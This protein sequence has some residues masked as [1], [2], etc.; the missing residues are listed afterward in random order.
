MRESYE[1]IPIELRKK[2]EQ[3]FIEQQTPEQIQI[4]SS[5]ALPPIEHFVENWMDALPEQEPEIISGLL[6][7]GEKMILQAPSK[8]GKSFLLMNLA[9]SLTHGLDW[10][11][12]PCKR[13][14]V[15]YC[16]FEL[17]KNNCIRRMASIYTARGLTSYE[18]FD[19]LNL[20]GD[21]NISPVSEFAEKLIKH[22]DGHGYGA[23]ILDPAYKMIEGD[24]NSAEF[25]S[26]FTRCIDRIA[27]SEHSA[28]IY[29]HHHSKGA[30]SYKISMNRG[31]GSG[32]FSRDADAILDL[33]E[34]E[35]SDCGIELE[36]GQS[37]WRLEHTLRDFPNPGAKELIFQFPVFTVTY[38]LK[39]A[40]PK[41][42]ANSKTNSE[43]GNREKKAR[44][45]ENINILSR[46]VQLS[47]DE[48][49]ISDAVEW[50]MG[51][52]RTVTEKTIR[53]Y[54]NETGSGMI[55]KNGIIYPKEL[56]R[57]S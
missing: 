26:S 49:S 39:D 31:S 19:I 28:V 56:Q 10:I 17:S 51:N 34:I 47:K 3:R 30:Q 29:A 25:V 12:Y 15:L 38:N 7:Y 57:T 40:K 24:E 5:D 37:A 53:N 21:K 45:L 33:S 23:I 16:N 32:V 14:K 22:I 54:V 41:Y 4:Q 20:R 9:T 18:G 2:Y 6:R 13:T 50:M 8:A 11:G 1:N 43:R 36:P 27:E 46:L 52:G 35:A 55:I 42:G 48:V 44:K